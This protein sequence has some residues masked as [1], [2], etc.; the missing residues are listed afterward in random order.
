MENIL[1]KTQKL[2][3]LLKEKNLKIAKETLDLY[4]PFLVSF[5]ILNVAFPL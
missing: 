1:L 3:E 4:V 2:F 5:L